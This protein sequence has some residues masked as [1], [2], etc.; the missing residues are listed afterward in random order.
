MKA[1]H[2]TQRR[3][4]EELKATS[5]ALVSAEEAHFVDAVTDPRSER[6]GF[7]QRLT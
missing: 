1:E 7:L 2:E 6:R 3:I 4:L 5:E